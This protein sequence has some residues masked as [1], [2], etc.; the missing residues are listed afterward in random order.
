[1][2]IRDRNIV[3]VG[4][5]GVGKS[6]VV[7]ALAELLL[8]AEAK[9]PPSLKFQQ[10]FML[11]ASSLVAAAP[12]RGE[13]EELIMTVLGEAYA[14]KNIIIYL[15]NSQLFFEEGPG[16]VNIENTIMPCLLYTSRCV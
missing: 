8:D 7:Q 6:T 5:P 1:M 15:D 13:L 9:I 3:L 12:G 16:S 14:A 2:C 11:D 10:V 4:Q